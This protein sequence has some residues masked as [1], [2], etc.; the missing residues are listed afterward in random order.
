MIKF[1]IVLECKTDICPQK[2]R[3][4]IIYGDDI[5]AIVNGRVDRTLIMLPQFLCRGCLNHPDVVGDSSILPP[6][7]F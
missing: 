1:P 4:W 7:K 2:G 5:P 3:T 6:P